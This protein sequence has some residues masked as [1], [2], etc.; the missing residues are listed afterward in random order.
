[1]QP[2]ETLIIQAQMKGSGAS[3]H[4][5][6]GKIAL[7]QDFCRHARNHPDEKQWLEGAENYERQLRKFV[8]TGEL[9][10]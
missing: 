1:M 8:A 10:K 3:I 4:R 7:Y 6:T 2:N 5:L 9:E